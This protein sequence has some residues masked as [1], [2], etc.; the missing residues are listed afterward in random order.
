MLDYLNLRE[1]ITKDL[2]DR[3]KAKPEEII[4][5]VSQLQTE[6]KNN[7]KELEALKKEL[8]LTKAIGCY[9]MSLT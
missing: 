3:F 1:Q 5:R 2:S 6:L 8:A 4:D 9:Q 7:Q